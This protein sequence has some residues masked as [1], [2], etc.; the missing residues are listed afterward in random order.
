MIKIQSSYRLRAMAPI[1][2]P[3]IEASKVYVESLG[4]KV[5]PH[6]ECHHFI[7]STILIPV[8]A[9]HDIEHTI[10]TVDHQLKTQS[11]PDHDQHMETWNWR[12]DPER[13]VMLSHNLGNAKWLITV[14]DKNFARAR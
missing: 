9:P 13:N 6:S 7:L 4:L 14:T 3:I 12:I 5:D 1:R 11:R 10:H 2:D 8:M